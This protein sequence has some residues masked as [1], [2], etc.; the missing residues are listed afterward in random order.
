VLSSDADNEIAK[1][2]RRLEKDFKAIID[3]HVNKAEEIS[4]E[5]HKLVE[6]GYS[7]KEALDM[8]NEIQASKQAEK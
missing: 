7:H 8:Y 2:I 5:I 4:K 1:R 6:L 3:V